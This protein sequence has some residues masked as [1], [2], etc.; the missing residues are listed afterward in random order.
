MST[1]PKQTAY[2]R[3]CAIRRHQRA[4]KRWS[5][6]AT[7]E[8]RELT[9]RVGTGEGLGADEDSPANDGLISTTFK[10]PKC[11]A[12]AFSLWLYAGLSFLKCSICGHKSST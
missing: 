5:A 4:L 10:C 1:A 3:D 8:S 12:R 9:V 11:G 2:Q 6:E 7:S